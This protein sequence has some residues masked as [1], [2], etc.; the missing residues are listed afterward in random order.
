MCAIVGCKSSIKISAEQDNG[1]A[2]REKGG[3]AAWAEDVDTW[4]RWIRE[5]AG[6]IGWSAEV[7]MTREEMLTKGG[8]KGTRRAD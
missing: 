5:L 1:R 3:S 8:L 6:V 7:N 2:A 4:W